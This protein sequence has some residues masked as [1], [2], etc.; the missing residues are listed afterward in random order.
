MKGVESSS[1][2]SFR[3]TKA[4]SSKVEESEKSK[5]KSL[6]NKSKNFPTSIRS[7]VVKFVGKNKN[8]NWKLIYDNFVM[9]S[10]RKK[11]QAH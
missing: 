1:S 11:I 7:L 9:C 8:K 3:D 4:S 5:S 2:H 10:P 6:S